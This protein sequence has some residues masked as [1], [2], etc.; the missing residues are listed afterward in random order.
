M[1]TRTA[2]YLNC[3]SQIKIINHDGY[4]Y[5]QF[6]CHL[7][8]FICTFLVKATYYENIVML[9]RYSNCAT[10][11]GFASYIYHSHSLILSTPL[12][13]EATAR[14]LHLALSVAALG[15][16]SRLSPLILRSFSTVRRHVSLGHFLF[17]L[18]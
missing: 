9:P 8:H 17:V 10:L 5:I 6:I 14:F 11:N 7:Y 12:G 16:M 3:R 18:P 15:A 4:M 2:A 13:R 1:V